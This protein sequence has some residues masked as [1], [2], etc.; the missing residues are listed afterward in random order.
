M[1]KI[2]PGLSLRMYK[3]CPGRNIHKKLNMGRN[4]QRPKN[5]FRL[6]KR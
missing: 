3:I 4:L 5:I 6:P 1:Y 2:Y